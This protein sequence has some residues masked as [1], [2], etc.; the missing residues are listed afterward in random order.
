MASQPPE[1]PASLM[2]V[3]M[4]AEVI[5]T[6]FDCDV[7]GANQKDAGDENDHGRGRIVGKIRNKYPTE[8][9]GPPHLLVPWGRPAWKRARRGLS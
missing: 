8:R 4:A 3:A 6:T 7:V 9:S 2:R 5:G 1:E